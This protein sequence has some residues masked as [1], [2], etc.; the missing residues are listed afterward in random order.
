MTRRFRSVIWDIDGVIIDSEPAHYLALQE[1]CGT[2]G[3]SVSEAEN[4]AMLGLGLPDVWR[5]LSKSHSL[6]P[7]DVWI[8]EV[9]EK[10]LSIIGPELARPGVREL[11]EGLAAKRVPMAA[12]STAERKIVDGNLHAIGVYG[13]MHTMVARE[14]VV[15]TKPDP[16]PYLLAMTRLGILPGDCV[17]VED[18]PTGLAAAKASG[19]YAVC[20]PHALTKSLDLSLADIIVNRIEELD[21]DR[22]A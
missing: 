15:K 9:V 18:T 17:V 16:E 22:I 6:P 4:S 19:A 11:I 8:D 13:F 3:F 10:Y 20:W 2:L 5:S 21:W 7:K 14:E 12:V 1:V